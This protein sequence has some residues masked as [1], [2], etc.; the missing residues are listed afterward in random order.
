[1]EGYSVSVSDILIICGAIVTI[2]SAFA[3]IRKIPIFNHEA[4][5]QKLERHEKEQYEVQKALCTGVLCL[6]TNARTGNGKDDIKAAE[7]QL[8]QVLIEK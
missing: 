3:V 1:M 2:G 5:I 6:L 4:R 8:Q 7:K